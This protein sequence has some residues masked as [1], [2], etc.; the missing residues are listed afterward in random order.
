EFATKKMHDSKIRKIAKKQAK[1][2]I[3]KRAPDLSVAHADDADF[4]DEADSAAE[5][6]FADSADFADEADSAAE[7]DFA[8]E[9]DN[10]DDA[11][12]LGGQEPDTFQQQIQWAL[13]EGGANASITAQSGDIEL[14]AQPQAGRYVLEFDAS[15][16]DHGIVISPNFDG[17]DA[18][19]VAVAICAPGPGGT[20]GEANCDGEDDPNQALVEVNNSAGANVNG[21]FWI[22]VIE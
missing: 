19:E 18:D 15:L 21:D 1:K 20:N 8:D 13:V 4:A 6:D 3:K 17:T 16:V 22:A 5:A 10:A 9:A 2:Q 11:D 7:A 12:S 14:V